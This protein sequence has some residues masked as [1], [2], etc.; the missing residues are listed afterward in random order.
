MFCPRRS[1]DEVVPRGQS[2]AQVRC[3]VCGVVWQEDT[4]V[5]PFVPKYG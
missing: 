5:E 4:T 3:H 1:T 2:R